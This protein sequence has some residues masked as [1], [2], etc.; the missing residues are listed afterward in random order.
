MLSYVYDQYAGALYGA[1]MRIVQS[2]VFAE[3]VLQDTFIKIWKNIH[4]YDRTK[5]RFFT[6][7][8]RIARNE[9][10]DKLR[11]A[12][13]KR[14]SKTTSID[15]HVYKV[16]QNHK[17]EIKIDDIG[18]KDLLDQ[19]SASDRK[20]LDLIYFKGYTHVQA[21][22]ILDMPLG[23]VKTRLRLGIGQLRRILVDK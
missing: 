4:Q 21:S 12:E 16:D 9:A 5:G 23:T 8:M 7:M 6:W 1:V 11:S 14:Q 17:A 2:E 19:L 10:I 13:A 3:E 18:I 15:D 22:E 20:I